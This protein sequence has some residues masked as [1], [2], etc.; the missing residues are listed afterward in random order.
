MNFLAHAFLSFDDPD[1]LT[2]NMISDFVKGKKKFDYPQAIQD[3]IQLHRLI[4]EFTDF[5]PITANAKQ[6][7]RPAYRLYSGA[8]V[9]VVFDHFLAKDDIQFAPYNGLKEFTQITYQQLETKSVFFPAQFQ[10][11]FPYMR[12]QNWLFGYRTAEGIY[13]SFGGLVRRSKYLKESEMAFKIFLEHYKDLEQCYFAFF[14]ELKNYA[15][16]KL[17]EIKG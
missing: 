13:K 6:F 12:M 8:F 5:H 10:M 4:D 11:M 9:D 15:F 17:A 14:P 16:E 3:G 7:F 1:I 2:G